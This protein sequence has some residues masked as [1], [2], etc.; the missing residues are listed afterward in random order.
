MRTGDST[1]YASGNHGGCCPGK[2][3]FDSG[4]RTPF[5]VTCFMKNI[6]DSEIEKARVRLYQ[7]AEQG[8]GVTFKL[9]LVNF[10]E[11]NGIRP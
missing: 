8:E 5:F 2:I 10:S 7:S 4:I 1:G 9:A 3:V 11:V 6:N